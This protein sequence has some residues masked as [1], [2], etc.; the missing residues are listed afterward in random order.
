MRLGKSASLPDRTRFPWSM[1]LIIYYTVREAF[2]C[3]GICEDGAELSMA[4]IMGV[5]TLGTEYHGSDCGQHYI[6]I[7]S[8]P[9]S[10]RAVLDVRFK[11]LRVGL[12]RQVLRSYGP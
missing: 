11:S 10:L 5:C 8:E 3:L 12:N 1:R 7:D 4:R 9:L 2:S 6:F